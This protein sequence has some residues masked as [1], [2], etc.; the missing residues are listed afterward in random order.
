MRKFSPKEYTGEDLVTRIK[1][2]EEEAL[3]HLPRI[4]QKY[5]EE[6]LVYC[7][8]KIQSKRLCFIYE[9][10]KQ[11]L[12]RSR[13]Q[14]RQI[15]EKQ[16]QNRELRQQKL[17]LQQQNRELW[18]RKLELERQNRELRQQ[19]RELV[20]RYRWQLL[21]SKLTSFIYF[22]YRFFPE[23]QRNDVLVAVHRLEKSK[24]S[25]R[26]IRYKQTVFLL[27]LIWANIQ[28]KFDDIWLPR[29]NQRVD[30]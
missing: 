7:N 10:I 23:E 1:K 5:E 4:I 30:K 8:E 2:Y 9:P 24:A 28:M 6:V 21:I 13:E 3:F 25:K 17:E 15:H 29:K 12:L 27:E 11:M 14:W 22:L 26:V 16:Q 18:Q 19:I 20:L